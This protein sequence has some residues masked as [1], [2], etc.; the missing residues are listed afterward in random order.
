MLE[1]EVG[2]A[3]PSGPPY[4]DEAGFPVDVLLQAPDK[5]CLGEC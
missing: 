2:L 3:D 4:A 1:H 5:G